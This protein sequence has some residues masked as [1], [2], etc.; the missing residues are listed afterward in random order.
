MP[1][2]AVN[3]GTT[4]PAP[5]QQAQVPPS[6]PKAAPKPA[7]A[8][9]RYPVASPVPGRKGFVKSPY[10]PYAADVDVR[11][12]PSGSEVQDPHTKKI[13]LVP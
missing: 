2:P 7:T 3:G 11:G 10:A 1:E 5:S 9:A 12:L 4:A 8:G 6:A 13:F